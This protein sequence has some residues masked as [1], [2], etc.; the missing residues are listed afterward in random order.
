MSSRQAQLPL[1]VAQY[2]ITGHLRRSEH[3]ALVVLQ[4]RMVGRI[5]ELRGNSDSFTYIAE[6]TRTFERSPDLRGGCQVGWVAPDAVEWLTQRIA[7]IPVVRNDRNW[8]CQN[9][10]LAVLQLLKGD[11]L[12]FPYVAEGWLRQELRADLERSERGEDT[13]EERLFP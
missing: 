8:D 11:Q 7:A 12:V 13:V 3:W 2:P 1:I 6:D 4:S 5:F 9:W 10:M